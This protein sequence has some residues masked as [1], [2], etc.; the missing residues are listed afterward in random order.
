MAYY[1]NLVEGAVLETVQSEF[2]SLVGYMGTYIGHCQSCT[3]VLEAEL[4]YLDLREK[5][6]EETIRGIAKQIVREL[7]YELDKQ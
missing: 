3:V 1:P 4:I 2:E 7:E 6:D 5:Y